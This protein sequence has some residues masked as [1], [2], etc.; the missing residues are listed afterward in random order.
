[1][2]ILNVSPQQN[3]LCTFFIPLH[4][5]ASVLEKLK[6]QD[7]YYGNT[8]KKAIEAVNN[9]ICCAWF[10]ASEYGEATLKFYAA[11]DEGTLFST[12]APYLIATTSNNEGEYVKVNDSRR[13]FKCQDACYFI[14]E[15]KN[16]VPFYI[17]AMTDFENQITNAS[18]NLNYEVPANTYENPY[19]EEI[20]KQEFYAQIEKVKTDLGFKFEI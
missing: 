19:K 12:F 15:P 20:S 8:S 2:K 10:E 17:F 1:M 14:L 7:W 13:Y 4:E 5:Q 3:D 16:K 11:D 9:G 18:I 6:K